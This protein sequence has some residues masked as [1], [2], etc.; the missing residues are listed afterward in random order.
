[1]VLPVGQSDAVQKLLKTSGAWDWFTTGQEP[2]P[3]AEATT[4]E[5]GA[6]S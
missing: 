6:E 3:A 2:A 4:A 1:M 5:S